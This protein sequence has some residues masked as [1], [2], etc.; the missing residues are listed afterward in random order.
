[1]K[2]KNN[3]YILRHGQT[4]YQTKKKNI[5]YPRLKEDKVS[6]TAKGK[7]RIKKVAHQLKK[8]NIDLIYASDMFRTRQTAKIVAKALKIKKINFNKRL[9]DIGFGVYHGSQKAEFYRKFP[10]FSEKRFFRAPKNGESWG[11]VQ[12][13][14]L[15]FLK[16]I[17]KQRRGKTILIISH[18]DSLWLLQG[19]VK[20][21]PRKKIL[22]DRED[23][24]IGT[25]ELR[26]LYGT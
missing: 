21:L 10:R 20:N 12:K 11:Q 15:D 9:R 8:K 14:M 2:F 19:A 6:L 16:E 13:R 18:G 7:Q 23:N 4:I 17:D 26:K 25:G 5:I 3:Y 1:M 24:Y 22:K